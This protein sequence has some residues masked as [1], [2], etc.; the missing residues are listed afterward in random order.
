MFRMCA[1]RIC[2][3]REQ[4]RLAKEMAECSFSPKLTP[5]RIRKNP[6]AQLSNESGKHAP[7]SARHVGS[8]RASSEE[9]CGDGHSQ[10]R[11]PTGRWPRFR[12]QAGSA[13]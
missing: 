12:Q 7:T 1:M 2:S 9:P 5:R 8:G 3:E 11:T 6:A 13:G 4:L 10:E